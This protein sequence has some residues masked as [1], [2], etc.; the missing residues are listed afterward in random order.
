MEQFTPIILLIL[1]LIVSFLNNRKK[2]AA[3]P[4]RPVP[5][6]ETTS[7]PQETD[8]EEMLKDIFGKEEV[9]T[10]E[11]RPVVAEKQKV[12]EFFEPVAEMQ[13]D[14]FSQRSYQERELTTIEQAF[15]QSGQDYQ[16][17][18]TAEAV[19]PEAAFE[20]H[21]GLEA[22]ESDYQFFTAANNPASLEDAQTLLEKAR[23]L[24]TEEM[25]LIQDEFEQQPFREFNAQDAV[26]FSEILNR[27]YS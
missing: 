19:L 16:S 9:P 11:T 6:P 13:E 18:E 10:Q 21:T 12:P 17:F 23:E 1:W 20:Q 5:R 14:T 25:E 8:L 3:P 2:Q 4:A 15:E 26:I 7:R 24:P 27:K 22:L